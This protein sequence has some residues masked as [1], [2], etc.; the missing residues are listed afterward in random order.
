MKIANMSVAN[1]SESFE[2]SVSAKLYAME[3]H[4]DLIMR[5]MKYRVKFNLGALVEEQCKLW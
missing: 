4:I 5:M 1:I 2:K 3:R